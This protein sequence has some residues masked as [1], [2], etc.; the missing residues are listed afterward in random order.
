MGIRNW[1]AVVVMV[2]SWACAAAQEQQH[3]AD[4]HRIEVQVHEAGKDASFPELLPVDLSSLMADKCDASRSGEVELS[5]IVDADGQPHNVMFVHPIG[6][7]LD[8][9]A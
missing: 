6:N 4:P 7:D 8:R 1:I 9:L 3:A 2:G 5:F